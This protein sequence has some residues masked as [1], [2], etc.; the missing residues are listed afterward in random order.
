MLSPFLRDKRLEAV[1]PHLRG[2]VLDIGCGVGKLSE[3]VS[4]DRYTGVDIDEESLMIARNCYPGFVF[5]R[6]SE[7][8]DHQ[9]QF[10]T[11]V[12]LAV[13][14]HVK[15]PQGFLTNLKEKL[16]PAGSIILTTPHASFGW[17]HTLG[18]RVGIFSSAAS[19]EHETLFT[20]KTITQMVQAEGLQVVGYER[21][22]F[23]ANQLITIKSGS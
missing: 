4:K 8:K 23:G 7:L 19:E 20:R 22:L 18:S 15:D 5:L 17:T 13:I 11:I 9:A 21:F 10:D 6:A 12:G 14:E 16:A 3:Y 2:R 1:L